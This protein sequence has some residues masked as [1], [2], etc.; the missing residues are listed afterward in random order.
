MVSKMWLLMVSRCRLSRSTTGA[1]DDGNMVELREVGGKQWR[2]ESSADEVVKFRS[3]TYLGE[4][5]ET[6]EQAETS[7]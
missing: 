3:E 2:G 6:R 1:D 4:A 7:E 5:R